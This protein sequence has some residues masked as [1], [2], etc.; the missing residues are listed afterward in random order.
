MDNGSFGLIW[1]VN[2]D[3][4]PS[5]LLL[6]LLLSLW[7]FSVIVVGDVLSEDDVEPTLLRSDVE[8]LPTVFMD[9]HHVGDDDAPPPPP[10][11]SDGIVVDDDML[12]LRKWNT[13][14]KHCIKTL[15]LCQR[16][17]RAKKGGNVDVGDLLLLSFFSTTMDALLLGLQ[18]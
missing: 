14:Q 6:L 8:I 11:L 13:S 10:P 1:I 3:E 4:G 17:M 7:S 5:L 18:L 15:Y 2:V 9:I 16:E 12:C